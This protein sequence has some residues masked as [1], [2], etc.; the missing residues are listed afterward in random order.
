[1]IITILAIAFVVS[2]CF[3]M[4]F[5]VLKRLASL[6]HRE[7]RTI[8]RPLLLVLFVLFAAH[9]AEVGLYAI[10]LSALDWAGF[11]TL[12]GEMEHGPGWF[13]DHYYFSLA[14]YTTLGIGDIIPKGEIR[15][16]AA[17]EALNGLVLVTWSASFTYLMMER[18]W[19]GRGDQGID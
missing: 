6:V 16:V 3:I 9:L 1:M 8:R 14:S 4:H 7:E 10:V 17:V 19:G 15:L 11:G 12:V 18:L 5:A 2:A 13:F